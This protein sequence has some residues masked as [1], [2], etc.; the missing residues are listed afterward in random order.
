MGMFYLWG[1]WWTLWYM[2]NL[3][4][5]EDGQYL[6]VITIM[7][8]KLPVCDDNYWVPFSIMFNRFFHN[9][10]NKMCRN[11]FH[12]YGKFCL[13]FYIREAN[14][15]WF[16]TNYCFTK[17]WIDIYI[18]NRESPQGAP[19]KQLIMRNCIHLST[20]WIKPEIQWSLYIIYIPWFSKVLKLFI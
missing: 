11:I 12:E 19:Q 1:L 3:Q 10:L 15:L 5:V 2:Y 14:I 16:R 6:V 7:G 18:N 4:L 9:D 17:R 20:C 13:F 8:F